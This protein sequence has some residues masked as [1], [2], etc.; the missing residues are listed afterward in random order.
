MADLLRPLDPVAEAVLLVAEWMVL[1]D[2]G[3]FAGLLGFLG[4]MVHSLM[5]GIFPVLLLAALLG[6]CAR[7]S[8]EMMAGT[9][10]PLS[11]QVLSAMRSSGPY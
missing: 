8:G 9:Q 3:S 10:A 7:R 11:T 6:Y 2:T 4:V 5:R 1:T